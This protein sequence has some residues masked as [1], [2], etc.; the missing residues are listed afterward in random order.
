[1]WPAQAYSVNVIAQLVNCNLKCFIIAY[2]SNGVKVM[3]Y[4]EFYLK[5]LEGDGMSVYN[6]IRRYI[7]YSFVKTQPNKIFCD[8]NKNRTILRL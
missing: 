1:M 4:Y 3:L 8:V 6:F 2:T 7:M 5:H